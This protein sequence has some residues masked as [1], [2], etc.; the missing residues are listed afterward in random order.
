M[1]FF[2]R[3]HFKP[4][5][6][7]A[8]PALCK[9]LVFLVEGT[10]LGKPKEKPKERKK[11]RKGENKG[12]EGS[13][14]CFQGKT[15]GERHTHSSSLGCLVVVSP[16][17][18][19]PSPESRT[20]SRRATWEARASTKNASELAHLQKPEARSRSRRRIIGLGSELNA[21]G[22]VASLSLVR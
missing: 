2:F 12:K 3:I 17:F 11:Q 7:T 1:F 16:F 22:F 18:P 21:H 20:R 10:L 14:F 15:K 13:S 8:S 6:P 5:M 4:G 19:G 9:L